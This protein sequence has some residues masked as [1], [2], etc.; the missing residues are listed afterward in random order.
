MGCRLGRTLPLLAEKV[1]YFQ[2]NFIYNEGK[3][4][5]V[6]DKIDFIYINDQ[7]FAEIITCN[8]LFIV[9]IEVFKII[10]PDSIL[11]VTASLLDL[12]HQLGNIGFQIDEQIGRRHKLDHRIK[13]VVVTPVIALVYKTAL[14]KIRRKNVSVLVNGS[15]LYCGPV[16][17]PDLIHLFKT[18]VQKIDLNVKRPSRHVL[19]KISHVWVF[20][21]SLKQGM[22]PVMFCE[23]R[24]K[25]GLAA[26]DIATDG[27]VLK[28]LSHK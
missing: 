24:R 13:N 8:P 21:H 25:G 22:P 1:I 17:V 5:N 10:E 28:F 23:F 18:T 19:I 4:I 2:I 16:V 3:V 6:L 11:I 14:I 12:A 20:I 7:K 27:N 9:P 26:S 15:V